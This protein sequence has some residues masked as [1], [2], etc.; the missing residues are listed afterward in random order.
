MSAVSARWSPFGDKLL[1]PE[2]H[3]PVAA[4]AGLHP[5]SRFINE[6]FSISSVQGYALDC[7][8]RQTPESAWTVR[9]LD[10][11]DAVLLRGS[12]AKK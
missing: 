8:L 10:G 4:I 1:P 6:H 11:Y 3:A 7:S 9:Y 12:L 2:G 5:N